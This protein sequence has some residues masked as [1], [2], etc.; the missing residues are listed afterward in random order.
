[1]KAENVI[2]LGGEVSVPAS[3]EKD[4]EALGLDKENITRMAGKGR[5][6]TNLKIVDELKEQGY[7]GNG[8]FLATGENFAD[9]LSAASV[10]GQYQMPIVLTDGKTLSAEAKDLLKDEDVFILGG[11][12]VISE[13]VSK[14]VGKVASSVDRLAGA[15]RYG[16]LAA[17]QK[18]FAPASSELFVASGETFP[19]ALASAPLITGKTGTL[20][21]VQPNALPQDVDA[22]LTKY[23]YTNEIKNVTVLGGLKA[24]GQDVRDAI[25]KKVRK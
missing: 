21:L 20:V 2:I 11:T 1:L 18:M 8:V 4:L 23:S 5:Y 13:E 6:E 3:I 16:T 24:V 10:A 19:D 12:S 22:F 9:A 14:E 15:N 17:I 25:E 7:E